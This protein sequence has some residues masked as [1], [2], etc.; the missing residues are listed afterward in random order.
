MDLSNSNEE[1]WRTRYASNLA[2]SN[3]DVQERLRFELN[4][5]RCF[6]AGSRR[7]NE[8]G[9]SGTARQADEAR[10]LETAR[11]ADAGPLGTEGPSRK[12]KR[13]N[14]V[15]LQPIQ[16]YMNIAS[17]RAKIAAQYRD[18]GDGL[19][20]AP[21]YRH[22]KAANNVGL[23]ALTQAN[24]ENEIACTGLRD[25]RVVYG[26]VPANLNIDAPG[27]PPWRLHRHQI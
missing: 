16:Q 8:A 4:S 15:V 26:P 1:D 11:R 12:R 10:P 14:A 19:Y 23:Q 27:G 6:P 25:V 21:R 24:L 20:I 22:S 3:R 5:Q 2:L 13:L 17:G 9:P 18:A 7:A